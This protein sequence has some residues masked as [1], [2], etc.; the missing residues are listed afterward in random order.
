[1][2]NQVGEYVRLLLAPRTRI[3]TIKDTKIE[4]DQTVYLFHQDE[5]FADQLGDY[6]AEE[7]DF[8]P[9]ERPTDEYVA[10][11]NSLTVPE[12]VAQFLQANRPS[13]YCDTCIQKALNLKRHQQA[14]Q[15]A[16]G[17]AASGGFIRGAG[18]C[19]VCGKNVEVTHA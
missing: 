18:T 16:S 9:C 10:E 17:G 6:W 13:A 2:S 12:K 3:G 7:G 15:A 14:Q 19:S 1:M 8:E 5:R 11:I 4:H